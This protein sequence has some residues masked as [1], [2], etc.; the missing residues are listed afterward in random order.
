MTHVCDPDAWLAAGEGLLLDCKGVQNLLGVTRASAETTMR[1]CPSCSSRIFER[2]SFVAAT[3]PGAVWR[4]GL[5]LR[6]GI[7]LR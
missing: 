7:R 3:S 4:A 1:Q 5:S 6:S 2:R